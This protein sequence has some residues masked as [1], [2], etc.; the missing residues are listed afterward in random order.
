[1]NLQ[2]IKHPTLLIHKDIALQ[3][4]RFMKQKA[5][6]NDLILRPHFK[7]HQSIEIGEWFK[8]EGIEQITVSSVQMAKYFAKHGWNDITIAFPL[9]IRELPDI[10]ELAQQIQLNILI[11]AVETAHYLFKHLNVPVNYFIKI[12]AGYHRAGIKP[13]NI[14]K[15]QEIIHILNKNK[16]FTFK[17]FLAHFGNTYHA[18]N[19]DEVLNI[20]AT[21]KKQLTQLKARFSAQFPNLLLSVGDTPSATLAD[22]FQDIDEIRPGNF[23][24]YDLMQHFIGVCNLDKI[25]V[26]LA[27]PVVDLYPE[28]NELLIYG[29]AVHL[30]KEYILNK[31]GYK[32]YGQIVLLNNHALGNTPEPIYLSSISQEHG[33]IKADKD[34]IKSV[35]IGDLLGI[36]PV[37]SCL[38]ADLMRQNGGMEIIC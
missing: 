7:T 9:N 6:K 32:I 33:I 17:G 2:N 3:N 18:T 16:S 24:Y 37:H 8:K 38:T 15:I 27:C 13:E 28:R 1:M 31:E 36:L 10:A 19:K 20:Y 11:S 26:T 25:A 29:G 23:V 35:K 30:S 12:D 21:S 22:D 5:D 4:I 34:F 14:D